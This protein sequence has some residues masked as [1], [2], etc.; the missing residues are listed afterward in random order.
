MA[1]YVFSNI[2]MSLEEFISNNSF[3]YSYELDLYRDLQEKPSQNP[4]E[5]AETLKDS[6]FVREYDDNIVQYNRED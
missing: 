4:Q 2:N 5:I 3:F 1:T 6:F